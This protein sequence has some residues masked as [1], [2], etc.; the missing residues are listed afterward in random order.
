MYIMFRMLR[1]PALSSDS[2]RCPLK[3]QLFTVYVMHTA[4]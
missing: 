3:T 2:F 4:Q 1:C